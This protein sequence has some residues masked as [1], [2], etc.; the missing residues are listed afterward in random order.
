MPP[1]AQAQRPKQR[2]GYSSD[3]ELH[4]I[5]QESPQAFDSNERSIQLGRQYLGP[6]PLSVQNRQVALLPLDNDPHERGWRAPEQLF[7]RRVIRA[8]GLHL[9][10]DELGFVTQPTFEGSV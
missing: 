5:C 7:G 4:W 2:L 9:Y 3:G 6:P 10:T 8:H 1:P